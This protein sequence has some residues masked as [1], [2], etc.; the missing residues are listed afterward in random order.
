MYRFVFYY[1]D[2][3][4]LIGQVFFSSPGQRPCE[5]LSSLGVRRPSVR[6]PSVRPCLWLGIYWVLCKF[7]WTLLGIFCLVGYFFYC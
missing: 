7:K 2:V 3:T 4:F 5:L 1:L 6:R